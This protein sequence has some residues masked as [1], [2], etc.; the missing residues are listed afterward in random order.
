[1]L[2]NRVFFYCGDDEATGQGAR[3]RING[4]KKWMQ[5]E[6]EKLTRKMKV[7]MGTKRGIKMITTIGVKNGNKNGGKNED[8]KLQR[9]RKQ[10]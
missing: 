3:E 6:R 10:I 4:S 1:M 7:K 8:K 9:K 2:Q 5:I